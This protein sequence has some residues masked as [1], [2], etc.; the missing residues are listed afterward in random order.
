MNISCVKPSLIPGFGDIAAI[1]LPCRFETV[2][3]SS[4]LENIGKRVEL[5]DRLRAKVFP[6]RFLIRVPMIDRDWTD[7]FR[8]LLGLPYFSDPTHFIE[9]TLECFIQEMQETRFAVSSCEVKWGALYAEVVPVDISTVLSGTN[10][11]PVS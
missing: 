6:K 9:F 8:R 10:E 2:V 5:L 3:L 1:D 7:C 4:V 11:G